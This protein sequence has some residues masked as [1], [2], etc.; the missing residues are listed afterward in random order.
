MVKMPSCFC[1]INEVGM[2]LQVVG[3][4][5]AVYLAGPENILWLGVCFI[6]IKN[7][8]SNLHLRL[9]LFIIFIV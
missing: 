4:F 1:K 7:C 9:K 6:N 3:M 5:C 2:K 8:P